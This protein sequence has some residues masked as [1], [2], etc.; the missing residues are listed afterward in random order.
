MPHLVVGG[1]GAHQIRT[2]VRKGAVAARDGWTM[3]FVDNLQKGGLIGFK[4]KPLLDEAAKNESSHILGFSQQSGEIRQQLADEI[5]GFFRFRWFD[6]SS[7]GE[8]LHS[9]FGSF[10]ELLQPLLE[11]E[12]R[13][14]ELVKPTRS[15]DA[16]LLPRPSF[17]CGRNHDIWSHAEA[18]NDPLAVPNAVKSIVRFKARHLQSISP[19]GRYASVM[20]W[21][22]D[23]D[24]VFDHR[25]ERHGDAPFPRTWKYSLKLESRFHFD[26]KHRAGSPFS[27]FGKTETRAV[28]RDHYVNI[29]VH[30]Y[31]R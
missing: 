2:L 10:G 19:D 12:E 29:D 17:S 31:F 21:T 26:V 4:S 20:N 13:W 16:L 15:S 24:R 27:L 3:R 5:K 14:A 28:V 30:G 22:D 6:S 8:L 9:D 18:Y 7:L 23:D 25:G 1:F 11:E